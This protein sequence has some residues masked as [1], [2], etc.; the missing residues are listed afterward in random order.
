MAPR[1]H[2]SDSDSDSFESQVA[3]ARTPVTAEDND[4]KSPPQSALSH[5]FRASPAAS[6]AVRDRSVV[7]VVVPPPTNPWEYQPF[8]GNTT[9]DSV[10]EDF[11]DSDG[12]RYYKIEYED[13]EQNEVSGRF[14][15]V[16]YALILTFK[17]SSKG[18]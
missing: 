18:A 10:L 1:E 5:R 7:A 3:A 16:R 11:E 12:Q 2:I 17:K 8:T 9:V 14:D 6:K 13:G 4:K 15:I